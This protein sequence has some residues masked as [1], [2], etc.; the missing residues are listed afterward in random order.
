MTLKGLSAHSVK[1]RLVDT[2]RGGE[3]SVV[4]G[5]RIEAWPWFRAHSPFGL[6]S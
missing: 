2:Q 5:D 1:T 3:A 6:E 4:A